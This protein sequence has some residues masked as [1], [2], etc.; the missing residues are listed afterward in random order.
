MNEKAVKIFC[1]L[2]RKTY[3]IHSNT[4]EEKILEI[5]KTEWKWFSEGF[6]AGSKK[7]PAKKR[8]VKEFVPPTIDEVKQYFK[9]N[10]YSEETAVRGYEH[11]KEGDWT[12]S[13]GRKVVNWKQK[14]RTNWFHDKNK[15]GAKPTNKFNNN[16][17]QPQQKVYSGSFFKNNEQTNNPL[18][19]DANDFGR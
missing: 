12:D 2:I 11:Y 15:I 10:G 16:E 8:T 5:F 6:E 13:D 18:K 14:M 17:P 9:D 3:P 19:E 1:E 7:A 4:T